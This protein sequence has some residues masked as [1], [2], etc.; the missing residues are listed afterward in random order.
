MQTTEPTGTPRRNHGL[1]SDHYLNVTLPERPD[2][3]ALAG[4][5][6]ATMADVSRVLEA[7][8]PSQNEAQTEED[9]VRPV[10]RLLGHEG[11]YEV[12]PAL[13]IPEGQKRPDYVF[14]RDTASRD[15][16]KDRKLTDELLAGSSFAV[17]DAKYWERP[18]DDSIKSRSRDA[19]PNGKDSEYKSAPVAGYR[20]VLEHLARPRGLSGAE[21]LARLAHEAD[22]EYAA[23]DLLE[24]PPGGFGHA[25]DAVLGMNAEERRRVSD[26]FGR[27]FLSS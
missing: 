6:E 1:F 7:Y 17:G 18:L 9:L 8:A 2:W 22:P 12:Q 16:N 14:Y 4:E 10:L 26:A 25:L 5:A 20:Y 11:T 24:R 13:V 23:E 3:R 15:A 19:F 27:T 21:E